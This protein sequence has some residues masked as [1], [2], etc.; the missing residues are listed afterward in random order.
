[1]V[2]LCPAIDKENIVDL[3]AST[4]VSPW[5]RPEFGINKMDKA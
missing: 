4:S 5:A 2:P 3:G 1:M